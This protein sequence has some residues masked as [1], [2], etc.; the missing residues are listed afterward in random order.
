M[1]ALIKIWRDI[2]NLMSVIFSSVA[3]TCRSLCES[4]ETCPPGFKGALLCFLSCIQDKSKTISLLPL[5]FP[6]QKCRLLPS[7][8]LATLHVFVYVW[9][10]VND[11]F[12]LFPPNPLFPWHDCNGLY[13]YT[14]ISKPGH[15]SGL[16][17]A[18]GFGPSVSL[19]PHCVISP[20]HKFIRKKSFL[21]IHQPSHTAFLNSAHKT[22]KADVLF[23]WILW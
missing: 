12:C 13:S 16:S 23:V 15:E 6:P 20:S 10:S 9:S 14:G 18:Q 3:P 11:V 19:A 1:Q 22:V 5:P 2:D 21:A 7:H 17:P 4:G 8:H